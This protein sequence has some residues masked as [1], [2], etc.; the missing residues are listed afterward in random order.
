MHGERGLQVDA[1]SSQLAP[2][3]LVGSEVF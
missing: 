2:A 1:K 3:R